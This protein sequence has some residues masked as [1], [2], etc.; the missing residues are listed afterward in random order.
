MMET[1]HLVKQVIRIIIAV[2]QL[3]LLFL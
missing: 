2:L 3:I 1:R